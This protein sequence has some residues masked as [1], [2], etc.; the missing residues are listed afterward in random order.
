MASKDPPRATGPFSLNEVLVEE[1]E[2]LRPGELDGPPG[3]PYENPD[4]PK[5]NE[6]ARADN[7]RDIYARIGALPRE[8]RLA[9]LC[10]S[11]GGIRSATFNLGVIQGLARFGLIERL[12]YLSTV[13]GGGY[14]GGWLKAWMKRVGTKAVLEDLTRT[15]PAQPLKPEARPVDRLREY[16]N[17][18]TPRRGLVSGDTWSAVAIVIRNLLLNW[19]VVVPILLA[20]V[21]VPQVYELAVRLPDDS[22]RAFWTI[23]VATVLALGASVS[24]HNARGRKYRN[25]HSLVVWGGVLPIVLA[26]AALALGGAWLPDPHGISLRSIVNFAALWC[27]VI[28]L[29][30]WLVSEPRRM[31]KEERKESPGKT[32]LPWPELA[33]LLLSGVITLVLFVG[34]TAGLY[35]RLV[36]RPVVYATVGVPLLIALYLIS[37]TIFV[38]LSDWFTQ[39]LHV[40]GIVGR[41]DRD[42]EWWARLSG[43]L[44]LA[45]LAWILICAVSLVGWL[46]AKRLFKEYAGRAIAGVGGIAGLVAVLIG[47]SG[48]TGS[49]REGGES[50]A[51]QDPKKEK[52]S[53]RQA[54]SLAV[55]A[56]VFCLAIF[57]LLAH[58]YSLIASAFASLMGMTRLPV[59]PATS[60]AT[61]ILV[62]AAP[63]GLLVFLAWIAGKIVN[64]NRFSLHGL[65]RNRLVRAY[66][67]ASNTQREETLDPFTGFATNDNLLMHELWHPRAGSADDACQQPLLVVNTTLNL[68]RGERLGWQERKAE[69][70][71]MTPFFCGNFYEGYRR[72]EAYGGRNGIS[73]GTALTISGA[74]ANPNM[75][76]HSSAPVTFLLG[77]LNARLGAWLGNTNAKGNATFKHQG[78]R[79]AL[80]PL[81]AELFGMTDSK[82]QYV[83]LSDG[84]HFDNLGLYEMVLRRCRFIIVSDAGM[85]RGP[86]FGDLGNAIRKV[87][88]DF[89]VP[90]EFDKKIGIVSRDATAAG[91]LCAMGSI[92]YSKVDGG[93]PNAD[94]VLIYLKPTLDLFGEG[95]PIPYD[96]FS[97]QRRARDFPHESTMDQWFDESQFES[98]RALGDYIVGRVIEAIPSTPRTLTLDEFENAV[99]YSLKWMLPA[100]PAGAPG[101]MATATVDSSLT[102]ATPAT[103]GLTEVRQR[104]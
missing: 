11:G 74:A 71:S 100:S 86:D 72:S 21:A 68:V 90:I 80:V 1:L 62:L 70:F 5:K 4:D 23:L 14:I 25:V 73:L 89:G 34:L 13:S 2:R 43:L 64:V 39:N 28:P 44:L 24:I 46:L 41:E 65:Y 50:A 17:Y 103:P 10:L 47:K 69:S 8:K 88:I 95:R 83:Q 96:V 54:F 26:S 22:K 94:G 93:N 36:V 82:K 55:A 101:G 29:I 66:L 79:S 59:A 37:R 99:R 38:A 9:A 60:S 51:N 15:R 77:I 48:K 32:R 92:R 18:L 85:D 56:P 91:T 20:I 57:V 53:R 67:G 19:L 98:Y 30:G 78:P 3:T 52:A 40:K 42:R 81:F 63:I 58:L 6:E 45:A 7:L 61:D 33:A 76:Y 102:P 84:G 16:S 104:D 75:G 27:V 49:G 31:I 87:R 12:D 35:P 97:Y